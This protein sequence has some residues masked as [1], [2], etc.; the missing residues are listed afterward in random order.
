MTFDDARDGQA[1]AK[2]VADADATAAAADMEM[3]RAAANDLAAAAAAV[4]APEQALLELCASVFGD[5]LAAPSAEKLA[6]I[7]RAITS[8]EEAAR[9]AFE[10]TVQPAPLASSAL[11]GDWRLVFTD[12]K[13]TLEGGVSGI[14]ALPFCSSV[15]VLQRLGSSNPRA[16]CIE[17]VGLP[18][19]V[20]NAVVLKGDWRL[21]VAPEDG[22][23]VTT[24]YDKAELAGGTLPPGITGEQEQ[25]VTKVATHVG[26][27]ARVERASNGAVYVWE[28]QAT[29]IEQTVQALIQ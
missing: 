6:A 23:L 29:P 28:R 20:K 21:D 3:I 24:M 5:K 25:R 2:R 14:G 4:A 8:L 13:P 18:L 9:T 11:E 12:S 7:Y 1:R 16:Q 22:L 19:G 17:I 27:R 26:S 15:A 10:G